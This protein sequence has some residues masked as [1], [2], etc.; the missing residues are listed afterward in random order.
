[1]LIVANKPIILSAVMLYVVMLSVVPPVKHPPTGQ[2]QGRV[3]N[4]RSGRVFATQLPCFEA[5]LPN[6][7]LKTRSKQLLGFLPIDIALTD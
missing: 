1:M 2:N 3:F 7:E 4:S 5:K 6:L